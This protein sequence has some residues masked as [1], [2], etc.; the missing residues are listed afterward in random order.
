VA[1][2]RP[3]LATLAPWFAEHLAET[4]AW[5]RLMEVSGSAEFSGPAGIF[6]LTARADRIDIGADGTL[7]LF[8][9]KTGTP[10]SARAVREGDAL[11]LPLSGLIAKA[12]G[13]ADAGGGA[14]G[15]LSYV[16]LSGGPEPGA[17]KTVAD[18]A[19]VEAA[20]D[21]A[22]A[23]LMDLIAR[24]DLAETPYRARASDDDF[25]HLARSA[26]WGVT[27]GDEA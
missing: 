18:A 11:Q 13:F 15:A 8:D 16:K 27:G 2:W 3:R 1:L 19:A 26:A 7:T 21:Q 4:A 6:T 23:I 22:E 12:G 5:R 14:I 24:Y 20:L 10:P 9:Y 17:V 25:A